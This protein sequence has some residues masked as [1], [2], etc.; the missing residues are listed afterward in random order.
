MTGG[1]THWDVQFHSPWMN[2]NWQYLPVPMVLFLDV[3]VR[4]HYHPK[5]VDIMADR[6][7]IIIKNFNFSLFLFLYQLIKDIFKIWYL[8]C[9][10]AIHTNRT[11]VGFFDDISIAFP[12]FFVFDDSNVKLIQ[13]RAYFWTWN[14]STFRNNTNR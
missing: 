3:E 4:S 11:Y 5:N 1:C 9:S 7:W 10:L 14:I 12:T 8:T 2:Q 6:N 13:L